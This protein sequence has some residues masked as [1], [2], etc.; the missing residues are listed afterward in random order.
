MS[1][2]PNERLVVLQKRQRGI[3]QPFYF[4]IDRSFVRFSDRESEMA[5]SS[6]GT[7]LRTFRVRSA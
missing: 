6:Y 7:R 2:E 5:F 3:W 1:N 4:D